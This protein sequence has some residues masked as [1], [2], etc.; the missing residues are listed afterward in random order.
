MLINT[1]GPDVDVP[2]ELTDH[3]V[4]SARTVPSRWSLAGQARQIGRILTEQGRT[5]FLQVTARSAAQKEVRDQGI[6]A[7]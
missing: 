6:Q 2:A 3:A 7:L 1:L 4:A 5:R